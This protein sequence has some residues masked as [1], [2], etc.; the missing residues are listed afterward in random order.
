MTTMT[1]RTLIV[2][3]EPVARSVLREEL[4]LVAD[5]EIVGEA[6]DGNSALRSIG[7]YHPDLILLDLQMPGM[8]GFEVVRALGNGPHLPVVIIVTAFDQHA[9]EAFETGAIDYLLKPVAQDRLHRAL[10]RARQL[11]AGSREAAEQLARLQ[12]AAETRP[13]A[14]NLRIVGKVGNEYV[15]LGAGEI[16]AFHIEG[17]LLWI[18]T[19]NQKY[20]AAHTLRELEKRLR[21][22][23]FR[24][25]HRGALINMDHARKLSAMSSQRWMVTLDNGLEF[26]VSRRLAHNVRQFLTW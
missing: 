9:V 17:E 19:A 22:T 20:L 11:R 8:S 23:N 5:V 26:I 2:D 25:I 3:D 10:A 21:H 14:D 1:L 4:E 24:R 18:R 7:R 6:E 16:Y 15:L 13:A 12:E